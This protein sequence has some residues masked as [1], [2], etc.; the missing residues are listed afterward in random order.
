MFEKPKLGFLATVSAAIKKC[1]EEVVYEPV[2]ALKD[3]K[4][5]PLCPKCGLRMVRRIG[6]KAPHVGQAF[7]GCHSYPVCHG[8]VPIIAAK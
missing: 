3:D 4:H 2:H 8:F 5:A 6:H 1:K 7:W